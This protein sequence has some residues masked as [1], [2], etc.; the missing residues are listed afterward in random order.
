MSEQ[1]QY[2]AEVLGNSLEEHGAV[3]DAATIDAVADDLR[4]AHEEYGQ[5]FYRPENPLI[6][7]VSRLKRELVDERAMEFCRE[8]QGSGRVEFSFGTR[9]SNSPCHKCG[10]AGKRKP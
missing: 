1:A 5:A 9:V 8:C 7:E 2:W 6:G 10:G 4:I 3:V